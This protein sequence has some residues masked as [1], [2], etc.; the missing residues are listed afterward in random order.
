MNTINNNKN[1]NY[2][3]THTYNILRCNHLLKKKQGL[4]FSTYAKTGLQRGDDNKLTVFKHMT[5][6]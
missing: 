5:N 4:K 3:H 2:I 6:L 1:F